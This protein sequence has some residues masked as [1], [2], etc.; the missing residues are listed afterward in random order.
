MKPN[1]FVSQEE[2]RSGGT[3]GATESAER[4]LVIERVFD[5]SPSLVF[6][7]WTDP[8]HVAQWWGPKGFTSPVCE[9]DARPGGAIRIVMRAPDGAEHPITGV[10]REVVEPKRL[11][12]TTVAVDAACNPII[13][14]LTTVTFA[15]HG[16]NTKLTLRRRAVAL[17]GVAASMLAGMQTGWT[18]SLDRLAEHLAR[19]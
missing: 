6:K 7:A 18:Q 4:V 11:V 13:D 12:F 1:Q 16:G 5:A 14:G 3:S 2:G 19:A 8:K 15:E 17:N 9:M 10:F